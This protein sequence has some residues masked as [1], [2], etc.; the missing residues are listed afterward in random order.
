MER[1]EPDFM[2]RTSLRKEHHHR[3]AVAAQIATGQVIDC[4]CGIGY[5]SELLLANG[6]VSQYTGIDPDGSAIAYAREKF[7][8]P[9]ARFQRGTLERNRCKPASADTFVMFETL[10]HTVEPTLALSAV[11]RV[12]KP[13]GVLVGSVPSA[14]YEGLCEATY[15]P[16]QFHLQRFT[17]EALRDVL[18]QHF[19]AVALFAAEF[20]VGSLFR[21]LEA[22]TPPA[23]ELLDRDGAEQQVLGSLLFLAGSQASVQAAIKRMNGQAQFHFAMAKTSLDA[24]EVEPIRKALNF[25]ELSIQS[26]D[27][28]IASQGKM[29][30]DRWE[31]LVNTEAMV[32]SRDGTI[33]TLARQIDQQGGAFDT[34]RSAISEQR[35][36]IQSLTEHV[37]KQQAMIA[38]V[39]AA[40]AQ[41]DADAVALTARLSQILADSAQA[42]TE[43]KQANEDL[44]QALRQ[45]DEALDET[46]TKASAETATLRQALEQQQAKHLGEVRQRDEELAELKA[47]ADAE[48]ATLRQALEQQQA[49]LVG[50]E[51]AVSASAGAYQRVQLKHDQAMAAIAKAH[52]EAAATSLRV[53]QLQAELVALRSALESREEIMIAQSRLLTRR[54]AAR[55]DRT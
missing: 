48:A 33:E 20:V 54:S 44:R 28:A 1:V 37:E 31:I 40:N 18:E 27:E 3:Y 17:A 45:R 21:P 47:R 50:L 55:T 10:E 51:G 14:E 34:A 11:A 6:K 12:L 39:L 29:L 22:G 26:R 30:E 15:G 36:L 5:G 7:S 16:N 24:E 2:R 41:K 43:A 32:R 8:Q 49:D 35:E 4:A 46:K 25:A 53:E 38:N 9:A 52:A 23:A 19:D 42:A 13:D